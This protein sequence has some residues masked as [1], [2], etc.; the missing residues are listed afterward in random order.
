MSIQEENNVKAEGRG[1]T[2]GAKAKVDK[3]DRK[4]VYNIK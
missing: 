3:R 4:T 1:I 2:N